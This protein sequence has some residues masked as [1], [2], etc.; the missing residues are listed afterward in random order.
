AHHARLPRHRDLLARPDAVAAAGAGDA[1]RRREYGA[2]SPL[3]G[4][5]GFAKAKA[6]E[7]F[8]PPV[9]LLIRDRGDIPLIRRFAPPSPTRGEGKDACAALSSDSNQSRDA[10]R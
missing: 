5:G 7:G 3:A 9:T 2:P 1:L 4:E 8:S 6:G 10:V